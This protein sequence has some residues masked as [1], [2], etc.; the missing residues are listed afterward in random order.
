MN[1]LGIHSFIHDSG[2]C[3]L[4]GGSLCAIS[5]E[6][7]DRVKRSSAFP[8]LSIAYT[9]KTCG[10]RDINDID[11][12]VYDLFERQGEETL[13]QIRNLGYLGRVQAI[14]HH[15]AHAASA[16]FASPFHDAAVMVV[17]GAGSNGFEYPKG[18]APHYLSE[19]YGWMQEV[20]SLYRG[21]GN[22]LG[23][24]QR[25]FATPQ[26][27]LGIGFLYGIACE[28]L[29]FNKLDGGKLMGLAS[30]GKPC[31][32]FRP[33][34]FQDAGNHIL[35]PFKRNQNI[36][37]YIERLKSDLFI[38]IEPKQTDAEF[39]DCHIDLAFFVQQ[40][41]EAAMLRQAKR[42]KNISSSD[43]LCMAGG[44]ALNGPANALVAEH[45]GFSNIFIQPAANDSG[46][47]LGCALYG[48]HMVLGVKKRFR[49]KSV[50]TA[51][52]YSS[53]EIRSA[54]QDFSG[55]IIA[56]RPRNIMRRSAQEISVGKIA[57]FFHGASEF[58]PRALGHRSILADPRQPN[59]KQILNEKVKFR[60]PFR[61][62]APA[63]LDEFATDYFYSPRESPFMLYI[64]NVKPEKRALIPAVVHVDNTARIQTVTQNTTPALWSVINEFYA[65]TGIPM[66][67]NTSMNIAGEP[68]AE[69]PTDAIEC[70][71]R[72]GM[73]ILVMESWLIE[74]AAS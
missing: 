71:L 42:L 68:I 33:S 45:S 49:M 31:G 21:S 23:L 27:A 37:D 9:M 55:K 74:K 51:H 10:I 57:G 5:E 64:V 44:V 43:N 52:R 72:T 54:I 60:E 67:I 6:R 53:D 32:A 22:D 63:V 59:M 28:Y 34:L 65:L 3:L 19:H 56:S 15:D 50:F 41:T 18:Q 16:Y 35:I 47:P 2:A 1:V 20:Q 8:R 30:Y 58:G 70:L 7:L 12:I 48:H 24:V 73:D 36:E 11:L 38:G 46:I 25:T 14:R 13:R 4:S 40:Q 61:P 62:Y 69:T 29:G 17:D 26:Y 66:L 39:E